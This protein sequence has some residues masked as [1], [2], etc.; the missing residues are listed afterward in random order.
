MIGAITVALL[1]RLC[2]LDAA[3][4]WLDETFTATWVAMP[5]GD[6]LRSALGDNHLPLYFIIVKAWTLIAGDS[7]WAIRFVSV[8]FS[9]AA[10]PVIA[11]IAFTLSGRSAALWAAW[12]TALSP[13]LV[14]HGQEARMYP[15]LAFLAA[16]NLLL[17]ARFVTFKS[18]RLS[19][20]YLLTNVAMLATHYYAVFLIAVTF[21]IL[22]VLAQRRWRQWAPMLIFG[23][24]CFIGPILAARY[25][26]TPVAGGNYENIGVIGLP[27]MMWGLLTGYT[28]MPSSDEMHRLGLRAIVPY[29]P[30][31][32]LGLSV[33]GIIIWS[34]VKTASKPAWI[35]L[36]GVFLGVLFGPLA[37]NSVFEISINPR[38]ATAGA[39][40]FI[41][42]LGMGLAALTKTVLGRVT[43]LAML[44]FFSGASMSHLLDPGHGRED[45]FAATKWL[46]ENVS[47][48][49][50]IYF[51]S[52]EFSLL[53][54]YHWPNRRFT[55]YPPST[56]LVTQENVDEISQNFPFGT[57]NHAIFLLARDWL[58]DPNNLL[59]PALR[60]R[61]GNCGGIEVRGIRILCLAK[62]P[63][64]ISNSNYSRTIILSS[65]SRENVCAKDSRWSS[66]GS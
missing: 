5:W 62:N 66:A 59:V 20:G 33:T 16:V 15:L 11:A 44:T 36:L 26:A 10:V 19:A 60:Q 64:T 28:L 46:N 6:M 34:A 13:F 2:R 24:V 27:G 22:F 7:P 47:T 18:E 48:Q 25:L 38:Y 55:A 8:V 17:L 58:S 61:Y 35:L 49:E 31:V 37:I 29:I 54:N 41:A 42:L 39:P 1:L 56:K 14:H 45:I 65:K 23:C 40:A 9:C 43:A 57:K 32:T 50:E 51:S 12:L 4:I 53:S 3:A 63:D 30:V 52:K 21:P